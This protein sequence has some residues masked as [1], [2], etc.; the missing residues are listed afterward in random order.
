MTTANKSLYQPANGSNVNIWDVPLNAN[1][2]YIDAA[3]GAVTLLNASSGSA[4]LS[5]AQYRPLILDVSG[6]MSANVTYTI[7]T[8]VGGQWIVRN[9]TTGGTYT[10]TIAYQGGGPTIDIPRNSTIQFY[11]DTTTSPATY[12]I[13]LSSVGGTSTVPGS[14]TQ[15]VFNNSGAFAASANFTWDGTTV[16]ASNLTATSAIVAGTTASDSIGNLRNVPPN[17]QTGAYVLAL[18]DNGKYVSIT[19]GGVTVPPSATAAFTAGQTV[20]VYNNS[21]SN[22]TITPGSGVTMTQA[23]TTNTGTRTLASYGLATILCTGTNA[24]VITGAGLT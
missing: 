17:A 1:A 16:T 18:S 10:V 5:L 12:G 11:C 7:P 21:A 3:F 13:Y 15:V 23:G 14:S 2:D 19:T 22:Q 9:R 4:T 6:A 20:S 24:F 8:G